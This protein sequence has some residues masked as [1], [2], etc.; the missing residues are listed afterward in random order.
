MGFTSA[1]TKPVTLSAGLNR[2]MVPCNRD[3]TRAAPVDSR[4]SY[5]TPLLGFGSRV[6][7]TKLCACS[8]TAMYVVN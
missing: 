8:Y 2:D 3:I 1:L 4:V 6:S 5:L 7:N